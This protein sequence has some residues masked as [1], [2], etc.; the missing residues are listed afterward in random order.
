[1]IRQLWSQWCRKVDIHN[2][3]LS[4]ANQEEIWGYYTIFIPIIDGILFALCTTILSYLYN[5]R[6]NI[7]LSIFVFIA[8]SIIIGVFYFLNWKIYDKS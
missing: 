2:L 5:N 4:Y 7:K 1:M 3:N 6:I 8:V